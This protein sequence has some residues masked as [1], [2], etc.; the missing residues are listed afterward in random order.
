M[1]SDN[2][3]HKAAH[4]G[5]L[6]EVKIYIEAEEGSDDRID[7][8]EPGKNYSLTNSVSH[9]CTHLLLIY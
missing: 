6:N 9:S 2:N 8:N 4:K 3:L 1:P 7:V 5:D